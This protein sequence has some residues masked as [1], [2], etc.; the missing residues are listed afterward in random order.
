[1]Y[2]DC[3]PTSTRQRQEGGGL[4]AT[5]GTQDSFHPIANIKRATHRI[6][7]FASD[8]RHAHL[9][10]GLA[11]ASRVPQGTNVQTSV[12]QG[13]SGVLYVYGTIGVANM[14]P[15]PIPT[16]DMLVSAHV[17]VCTASA[18]GHTRFGAGK[19]SHVPIAPLMS[20]CVTEMQ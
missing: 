15:H 19:I 18:R 20:V 6:G 12:S 16:Q 4:W 5:C 17:C 1:M 8:K 14:H 9:R 2:T 3:T 7:A 10:T 11:C 13:K